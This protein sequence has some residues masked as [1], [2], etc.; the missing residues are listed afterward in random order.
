MVQMFI[1]EK[2]QAYL[3]REV[4]RPESRS[5]LYPTILFQADC[6]CP[7]SVSLCNS[8]F[9]EKN[10]TDPRLMLSCLKMPMEDH[11]DS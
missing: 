5:Y 11:F 1:F 2:H 8:V 3:P 9:P 6:L 10:R 4:H 7:C